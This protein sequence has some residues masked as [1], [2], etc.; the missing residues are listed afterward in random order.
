M[1][2]DVPTNDFSTDPFPSQSLLDVLPETHSQILNLYQ[3]SL[4][5][6]SVEPVPPICFSESIIR[7]AK[8]LCDVYSTGGLDD[9]ALRANVLGIPVDRSESANSMYPPRGQIARWAMRAYGPHLDH[10][11]ISVAHKIGIIAGLVQVM[12]IIG[13]RRRRAVLLN[14]LLRLCVPHLIQARVL[15]A[16]ERG[17]HPNAAIDLVQLVSDDHGLVRLMDSLT[18]VYGAII[19]KD[20]KST[21]GWPV[22]RAEVLKACIAVCEALPHPAGVARFTSLLFCVSGNIIEKDEQIRLAGNMPRAVATGRKKDLTVE[23]DYW[24]P[25][26][27]ENI[28]VIRYEDEL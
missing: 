26:L 9:E 1:T 13:F 8:L 10:E 11:N 7:L 18:E 16:A 5:S 28:E 24:D 15:G 22:L 2:N 3:R 4:T 17:L 14:E 12:G 25:F 19:P 20:D 23:A 6:S 21:F 27:I